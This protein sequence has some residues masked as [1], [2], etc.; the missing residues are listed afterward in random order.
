LLRTLPLL[1]LPWLWLSGRTVPGSEPAAGAKQSAKVAR[2][3][4]GVFTMHCI[5]CHDRTGEGTKAR[6]SMPEIP[7]F[8]SAAWHQKRTDAQLTVSI[9][10]GKGTRMPSFADR[11]TKEEARDLAAH[12][13][14]FNPMPVTPAG[15]QAAIDFEKRFRELEEEFER[16]RKQLHDL[17]NGKK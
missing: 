14:S 5:K 7:D 12:V 16:L 6:D 13:R 17:Q 9:L 15:S 1:V 2:S 4:G 11:L 3:A 8:T 10:E